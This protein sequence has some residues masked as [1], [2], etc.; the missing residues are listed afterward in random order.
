MNQKMIEKTSVHSHFQFV[1][2]LSLML[3]CLYCFHHVVYNSDHMLI[4]YTK[5]YLELLQYEVMVHG[6]CLIDF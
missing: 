2:N 3:K 1:C 5:L 6:S 4:W